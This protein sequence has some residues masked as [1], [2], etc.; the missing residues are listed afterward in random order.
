MGAKELVKAKKI[1]EETLY[2][3]EQLTSANLQV[4]INILRE[5]NES[6][7]QLLKLSMDSHERFRIQVLKIVCEKE[8]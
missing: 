5:R 1:V 8:K 7:Q 3:K 2:K 4:V 6:L